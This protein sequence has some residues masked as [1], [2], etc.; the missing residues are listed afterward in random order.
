MLST[1]KSS[2]PDALHEIIHQALHHLDHVLPAQAPI[3]NFVHHNTIHGFQHLPFEQALAEF[4]SITG[5]KGYLPEAQFRQF[6]QQGRID[7]NDLF[8]ALTQNPELHSEEIVCQIADNSIYRK[9]LYRLALLVDFP[10]ITPQQF[11]WQVHELKVL[12][13]EAADSLWQTTLAKLNL[14]GFE[15]L[16]GLHPEDLFE[17]TSQQ[18][19]QHQ[20]EQ[21][22][23]TTFSDIGN[24]QTLRGLLKQ[25]TGIDILDSVRPQLIRFCA[26]AL[27]EGVAAWQ[28][29][30]RQ[31]LGLYAAWRESLKYDAN[32][33]LAEL[34]LKGFK[35][36]SD[37]PANALDTIILHL[38]E[39]H[40]P[41]ENW[42]G[43]LQRLALEI[44][45]WAGMINWRQHNPSYQSVNDVKPQLADFL[46]IRLTL[47]RLYLNKICRELWRFDARLDKLHHYFA[48]H[49]AEFSVRSQFYQGQLPEYLNQQA[50]ELLQTQAL[51]IE[52]EQLAKLIITG[53]PLKDCQSCMT[54]YNE[55]WR[56]FRLCQ[57]L[58]LTAKQ[59]E[60]LTR[61][62]LEQM[63]Q[64]LDDFN[65]SAR[66]N[67]WLIA[68]EQHYRNQIFNALQTNE[69]R[70]RWF[71]REPHPSAQLVFCMD[72]R[73]ESIRRHVEELNPDFET[74][75]AAGF[76]GIAMN[77]QG[78][79]DVEY[80][81]LCPVVVTPTHQVHEVAKPDAESA[82]I[83]H[84]KGHKL[85]KK[86]YYL[87]YQ[88]LR[89]HLLRSWAALW[90]L[91]PLT[92]IELLTKTFMPSLARQVG[93]TIHHAVVPDV[94]TQLQLTA[95]STSTPIIGFSDSEQADRV[96]NFLRAI[97]LTSGF[98]PIVCFLG[99]GSTSLN[100]PHE[101]AH[102][103]GACGGRRGGPN[104]RA[105]AAMAN[106][107]A[108]RALLVQRG[109]VIPEDCWFVG[110]QH[111]T[112]SDEIIWYDLDSIPPQFQAQFHAFKTKL[113]A[114]R[115]SAA[116]ERCRR[117]LSRNH[118]PSNAAGLEHVRQRSA[119]LSQV[120]PEFGHAT[121]AVAIIGRRAISQ[122]LFLDRRAFLISY[123]PTQ[124]ADGKILEGILLTAGPVGA[125]I[126]LEY[127]FSTINNERFG[128]GTKIPHNI[129]GLFAV[130][131][132]ASSDLRTGLPKQM[133]EIHE[134]M[135]LQIIVEAKTSVLEQIYGRQA[136]LQ[137]LIG[138]GWVHLSAKDP[139]SEDIFVFERGNGFVLWQ[140]EK[141]DLP[142]YEKSLDY[143][144]NQSMA[145]S[146]VLIQQPRC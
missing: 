88:S 34:D 135:R 114:A 131:E 48:K 49:L 137:E 30:E 6:Y 107:A 112:C 69:Q 10:P 105:F 55:G 63:L 111:D 123:D 66:N 2:S 130:M 98:A 103:C 133:V 102:D 142:L 62:D 16:K 119:D 80:T 120:R 39:Q 95:S 57:H 116:H 43:Y 99:H 139:D 71:K 70:G 77:Y 97:G 56:L 126:N 13:T 35:N 31:Q 24:H 15:N 1:E 124:D 109:I 90:A 144:R 143:Y 81:P 14:T 4:E 141:Q 106:R 101:A 79:D 100:N 54:V 37:L 138:G 96:A 85:E 44:P 50:Q 53:S 76:F 146:P 68:Y 136:G 145:L 86:F 94:P 12:E 32:P 9:D 59:L 83:A 78:L 129:T 18:A 26:S 7:D 113:L 89:R 115:D 125:G 132:G 73:E 87:Q 8:A 127:Y 72:E 93:E 60:N 45:G 21:V 65:E 41:Q 121:N 28:L 67:I 61:A 46:A 20:A 27:D 134:A 117:L 25:L 11:E 33:F 108:V 84:Y 29:P 140:A 75:G 91:A 38:T 47:D 19:W 128:C 51:A 5:I 64:L 74:L 110:T 122:G 104:A 82:A 92:L 36:L 3:M 118:P 23:A 42:A 17:S 40:I 52:F 58:G 22:L